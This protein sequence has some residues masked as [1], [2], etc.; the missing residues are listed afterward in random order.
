M[1]EEQARSRVEA[2]LERQKVPYPP[3][4]PPP[5]PHTHKHTPFTSLAFPDHVGRSPRI[6]TAAAVRTR[7]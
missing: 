3:T 5:S 6:T 4:H 7:A 2:E 1:D